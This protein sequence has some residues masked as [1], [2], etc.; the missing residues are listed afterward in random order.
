MVS[1]KARTR[2]TGKTFVPPVTHDMVRSLFDP[3]LKKS[4]L[5]KIIFLSLA[6][7][8]VLM[9]GLLKYT[10]ISLD[11]I[12]ILFLLQYIF[13]RFAYNFGIGAILHYQS[14]YE[15]FSNYSERNHLF[16]PSKSSSTLARF[17]QYEIRSKMPDSYLMEAQPAELNTWLVFRQVVDLI[18]MQDFTTYCIY[19]Y[20]CLPSTT[21]WTSPTTIMGVMMILLN[22]WVKTDA[23]RVV[24]DYAWYWG[25]FFFLQDSEL[26]FD[27]V[28]NVS[29]HPMYSIGYIGYYAASLITGDYNVLLVSIFGHLLQLLFLKYVENPHIERTYGASNQSSTSLAY[30]KIDQLIENSTSSSSPNKPLISTG[31][32]FKNFKFT[33]VTDLF[34][35]TV[36][37]SIFV[38]YF[39]F[40]PSLETL[41]FTTFM[42][43]FSLS[44]ICALILYK[45][46]T[47]KWF[48]S[49]FHWRHLN[50]KIPPAVLAYQHWQFIYNFTLTI[51]NTLLAMVTLKSL[52]SLYD[53]NTLNYNQTIFGFLGIALQIWSNSEIR[54]VLANFGYFYGDFFLLDV[55]LP[56]KLSYQGI[57]RYLNNPQAILGLAGIW[58]TVLVSNFQ[59]SNI[60]L[61]SLWTIIEIIAVKFIEKPHVH[62]VYN[63]SKDHVAG[64][65]STIM[66]S[67]PVRWIQGLIQ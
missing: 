36:F 66:S 3:S 58:G 42:V 19:T 13:W 52:T 39:N 24:K 10:S 61:A 5:E 21:A 22:V 41:T 34:T 6:L 53:S 47:E 20:L 32:G 27:G 43:K 65:E 9:Y 11:T 1:P 14:H 4:F 26:T 31:L 25:D 60:L 15:T 59:Y 35:L 51:S 56:K 30:N 64:V 67:K 63:D 37:I 45:Q 62:K 49:I 54:D 17:V 38:W 7:D 55:E 57:Y 8:L 23:H 29:P 46:S 12:K 33:R 28:F 44:S 48:T 2:S 40:N 50:S 18:L 16:D